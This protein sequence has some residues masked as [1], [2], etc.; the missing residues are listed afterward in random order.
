VISSVAHRLRQLQKNSSELSARSLISG[1]LSWTGYQFSRSGYAFAPMSIKVGVNS[2]CNALCKTCDIGIKNEDSDFFKNLNRNGQTIDYDQLTKA[3][4]SVAPYRP[5]VL[6]DSTEPLLYKRLPELVAHVK[7]SGMSCM[8]LT[9]GLRLP[10]TADDLVHAGLDQL[11]VSIDGTA[12]VHDVVRGVPGMYNRIMDGLQKV[13]DLRER[14]SRKTPSIRLNYV[15]S[16]FSQDDMVPFIKELIERKLPIERLTF[17]HLEYISPEMA[18]EHNKQVGHLIPV[19]ATNFFGSRPDEVDLGR[20]LHTIHAVEKIQAPFKIYWI[21]K[22]ADETALQNYYHN[23][24]MIM[25]NSHCMAPWY[26]MRINADGE[27]N[28]I[29]RCFNQSYGNIKN[30]TLMEIFNS[31]K[32]REFRQMLRQVGHFPACTRCCGIL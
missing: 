13:A 16:S 20:L 31:P 6:I 25:T 9:N 19:T 24:R 12:A 21:P 23:N 18:A 32:M 11:G 7:S 30:Q 14:E 27:V 15:I 2:V 10:Q 28:V 17:Y 1:G 8:V 4:D 26:I 29:A 22:L 5:K 3:L